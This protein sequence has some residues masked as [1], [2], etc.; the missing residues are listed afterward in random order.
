[1]TKYD[2]WDYTSVV[3]VHEP[4]LENFEIITKSEDKE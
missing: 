2:K 3:L 1:L 4:D